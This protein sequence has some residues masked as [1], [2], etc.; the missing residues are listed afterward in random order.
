MNKL[1]DQN[2]KK[3]PHGN[4]CSEVYR[5]IGESGC[6]PVTTS[7]SIAF[8]LPLVV[9]IVSVVIFN[10]YCSGYFDN[11]TYDSL[12]SLAVGVFAAGISVFIARLVRGKSKN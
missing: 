2:C 10:E 12:A 11:K 1:P 9:F 3:C 4:K 6:Q 7:V 8:L 5:K